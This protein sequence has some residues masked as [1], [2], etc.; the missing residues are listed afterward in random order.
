MTATHHGDL[1]HRHGF[2]FANAN[3]IRNCEG[4][5]RRLRRF[6]G[7][8]C[9]WDESDPVI[10]AWEQIFPGL[11][12]A[13]RNLRR[14]DE[15]PALSESL[16]KVQRGA[17]PRHVFREPVL[18]SF[19]RDGRPVDPT[20]SQQAQQRDI[21]SRRHFP[22]ADRRIQR[23]PVFRS[24]LYIPAGSRHESISPLPVVD[25]D[26]AMRRAKSAPV[27]G[28][29]RLQELMKT[30]MCPVRDST[31]QLQC[32]ADV[33]GRMN[34]PESRFPP[35]FSEAISSPCRLAVGSV[36]VQPVYVKS[37]PSP[38]ELPCPGRRCLYSRRS[39]RAARQHLTRR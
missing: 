11:P 25:S 2:E 5:R 12:S 7:S 18:F 27:H 14:S 10:K 23:E 38:H 20:E 37:S 6:G 35:T 9:V 15:S 3:H 13:F 1:V 39:G 32:L 31:E 19:R 29:I 30:P 21:R 28:T 24:L 33:S 26:R 8:V 22:P 4:Y 36:Y 17:S 34:L 16:F